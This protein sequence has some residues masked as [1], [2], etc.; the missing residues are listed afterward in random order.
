MLGAAI[1]GDGFDG[2]QNY[3][4]L[5]WVRK[6]LLELG[7]SPWHTELLDYP[8][9]ASLYFHT[10]NVPNGVLTLPIQESCGLLVAYNVVVV[11]SF[12]LGG[13]GTYLLALRAIGW[14]GRYARAAAFFSGMVYSASP[15]HFAHLLGHMQVFSFQWLP[16]YCVALLGVCESAWQYEGVRNANKVAGAAQLLVFLL[17]AI[18][19][20]W[21]NM[22]Y[23]GLATALV[24]G[25]H[26]WSRRKGGV[27]GAL[28]VLK[29]PGI[30]WAAAMVALSPLLVP[31]LRETTHASYMVPDE[32]QIPALSADL[33][34]FVLPQEMH[35]L[36]GD[37]AA[38]IAERFA[39]STSERMVFLGWLPLAL[40]FIGWWRHTSNARVFGWL[41]LS[42]VV[43]ALGP[44]LHVGGEVFA[45]GGRPVVLPYFLLYELVPFIGIARSVSRYVA[46]ATLSLAVLAG[47]GLLALMRAASRGRL[48]MCLTACALV[49]FEFLPVPYPMSI[50]DVPAW[51]EQLAA[52]DGEFAVLNL[53]VNWDRPQYLLYQTVHGKPLVAGYISR[54]NPEGPIEQYPGLQAL[55]ALGEDVLAFPDAETFATI[56]GDLSLR[57]VVLDRYQMPG[58]EERS[59]T[60]AT[61]ERLLK[62]QMVVHRDDRI[63]VYRM[64][65]PERPRAYVRLVGPWGQRRV[66]GGGPTRDAC[67]DCGLEV[68]VGD[69]PVLVSVRCSN[70]AETQVVF[71]G[72]STAG[73]RSLLPT[74]SVL[75]KAEWREIR[76]N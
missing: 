75:R 69:C 7:C 3:W 28:R 33:L 26:L 76:C 16:F 70:G 51:Y 47:I 64:M 25:W 5:W 15:F 38:S 60:E 13:L 40:G 34:A 4:N 35:P 24:L 10:L 18:L 48:A 20:D 43:L 73:I 53:P 71:S 36:W 54:R 11:L 30:A 55:R 67:A 57:Y 59:G 27:L 45:I 49:G 56:A 58:L 42:F 19:C 17:L 1:P 41:F 50:P 22:V 8:N 44:V 31:M 61:A 65:P 37:W 66:D 14:R 23:L 39:A 6:S 2:W 32:G 9:G 12:A 21:Y 62:G 63:T 46:M 72:R 68:R 29:M 52:E 74:C